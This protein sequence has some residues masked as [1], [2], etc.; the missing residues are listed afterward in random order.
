MTFFAD[1]G[2]RECDD[3]PAYR[4]FYLFDHVTDGTFSQRNIKTINTLAKASARTNAWKVTG[5]YVGRCV[6]VHVYH[7][8]CVRVTI[9][10]RI[11][12]KCVL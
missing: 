12:G 2:N 5:V 3:D 10:I 6:R 8:G 11:Y 1:S 7:S 4:S 9:N